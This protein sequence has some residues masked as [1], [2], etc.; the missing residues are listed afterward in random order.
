MHEVEAFLRDKRIGPLEGF[1]SKAGWPFTA[2]MALVYDEEIANW[3]LE[4]DFGDAAK[5]GEG[6]GE[7]VDFSSQTS[8]APAPSAKVTFLS[9]AAT[10]CASTAW[11]PT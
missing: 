10:T 11:V 6:D 3:K 8:W 2:E 5:D 1:R 9:T 4:F 7:P